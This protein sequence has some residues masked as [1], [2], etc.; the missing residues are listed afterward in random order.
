MSLAAALFLGGCGGMKTGTQKNLVSPDETYEKSSAESTVLTDRASRYEGEEE[1][2]IVTMYL[3]VGQGN[4]EDNTDHTWTEVN[5]YP[6]SYYEE[7]G[8]LP[9]QCEAVLQVGDD[10]GPKKGEFGYGELAANATVRLRGSGASRQ[11]QKSYRI[12]IKEGKGKWEDQKVVVLNKHS[13]DP[14][15]FKN[16][17]AYSL[18]QEIPGLFSART[19]FVHL[20][21]KDKTEGADGLFEDYGLYTQV[22]QPNKAYL[23][24][25][26]LDRDGQLYQADAFDWGE[27]EEALRLATDPAFSREEFE[28]YLEVKGNEDHT[29][30]LKLLAAVNDETV[31][32]TEVVEQYFVSENLYN[33]L[34]FQIL[35]GNR[36][37]AYGNYYLFSPQAA[38]KWYFISWNNDGMLS[39]FYERMRDPS[40]ENSWNHGIFTYAGAV[41]FERMLK[42]DACRDA[43]NGAVEDLYEKYLTEEG[44]EAL[45][46]KYAELIKPHVYG[47]PDRLYARVDKA[48]YD[49][50]ADGLFE[51]ITVH[52]EEYRESLSEPWPFHILEP[53][54][55]GGR[56]RLSWEEA[57]LHGGGEVSYR[58]ELAKSHGFADCILKEEA[59]SGTEVFTEPLPEGQYFLRVRAVG[60]GG[61]AQDAYE[62][63]YAES[64]ERIC[65]TMCFYVLSDGTIAVSEFEEE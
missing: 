36:E 40:W 8:V 39:D 59:V 48:A 29:K 37:A 47:L 64:G 31:P 16:R 49:V 41:L 28:K 12:T 44:I 19:R 25:H 15:R 11:P 57:Y 26:G 56:L 13:G 14:L 52:Y 35:T 32:V 38:D 61:A 58:V 51:E 30:L 23:K 7:T 50:L 6:T 17:L 45:A 62:F 3:T 43:L 65:S 53:E 27:H 55:D 1:P 22:E 4:K 24:N 60:P 9:Y 33:W 63:C 54:M 20:Y 18:M 46:E 5:D 21:V 34:A 42:E 10:V 2:E